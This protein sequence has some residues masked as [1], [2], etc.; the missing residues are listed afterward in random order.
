MTA[1]YTATSLEDIAESFDILEYGAGQDAARARLA[2]DKR[3]F[4][5]EARTWG[6]A[7]RMLRE[8]TLAPSKPPFPIEMNEGDWPY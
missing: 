1:T 4:E 5:V 7:A 8:T 6:R 2:K 3:A